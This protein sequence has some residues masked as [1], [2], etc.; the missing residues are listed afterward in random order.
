MTELVVVAIDKPG[1][2]ADVAGVLYANR[3]EVVDAAI[4][5]A[6][7]VRHSETPEG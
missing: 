6:P 1:L 2:L 5:S 3:I 4:Y 7:A